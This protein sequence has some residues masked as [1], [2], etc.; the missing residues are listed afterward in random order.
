MLSA[1]DAEYLVTEFI[2]QHATLRRFILTQSTP[3]ASSCIKPD[4]ANARIGAT[5]L[6]WF[7]AFRTCGQRRIRGLATEADRARSLCWRFRPQLSRLTPFST[8]LIPDTNCGRDSRWRNT[9]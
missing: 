8:H 9:Q 3:F 2:E 7:T 5:Y 1:P 4:G 6:R